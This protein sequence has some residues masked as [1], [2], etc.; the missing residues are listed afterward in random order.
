MAKWK[1]LFSGGLKYKVEP[2]YMISQYEL[3]RLKMQPFENLLEIESAKSD[4]LIFK[5]PGT[6]TLAQ[7]L[8][9]SIDASRLSQ[10]IQQVLQLSQ[11][12]AKIDLSMQRTILSPEYIY[13]QGREKTLKFIYLP[14]NGERMGYDEVLFVKDLILQARLN[15]S[16]RLRWDAWAKKLHPG[17]SYDDLLASMPTEDAARPAQIK[18]QEDE[19]AKTSLEEGERLSDVFENWAPQH[20]YAPDDAGEAPT[21]L[22]QNSLITDDWQRQARWN[23]EEEAPTGLEESQ[24]LDGMDKRDGTF[25]ESLSERASNTMTA[26]LTSLATGESVIIPSGSFT[27]GRSQQRADYCIANNSVSNIHA[28]ILKNEKGCFIKDNHSTNSTYVDGVRV[29]PDGEPIRLNDGC[30]IRLWTLEYRFSLT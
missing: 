26:R 22:E 19:E 8:K 9:M 11:L 15:G 28:T 23:G 20:R 13:V 5:L 18:R 1:Q 17:G 6:K 25:F 30:I 4:E 10:I 2:E 29:D 27:L 12:L 14:V 24:S 21:G 3:N 7:E 16:A